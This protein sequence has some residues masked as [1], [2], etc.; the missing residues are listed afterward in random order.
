MTAVFGQATIPR[1]ESKE[2]K[3]LP[4]CSTQSQDQDTVSDLIILL[5]V[6]TDTVLSRASQAGKIDH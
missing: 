6:T 5:Q 1:T 2:F 3:L 4:K